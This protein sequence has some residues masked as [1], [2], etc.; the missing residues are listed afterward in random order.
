MQRIIV[1]VILALTVSEANTDTMVAPMAGVLIAEGTYSSSRFKGKRFF[2]MTY[3]E[4]S[5]QVYIWHLVYRYEKG[6][7]RLLKITRRE[8]WSDEEEILFVVSGYEGL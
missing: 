7:M 2:Q 5:D 4:E 6:E 8:Q 1:A 3:K